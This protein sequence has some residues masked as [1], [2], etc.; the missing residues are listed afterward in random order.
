MHRCPPKIL[1]PLLFSFTIALALTVSRSASAGSAESEKISGQEL[2]SKVDRAELER[3]VRD[4]SGANEIE[5]WGLPFRLSTRYALVQGKEI[6]CQYLVDE[7]RE[8]GYEPQLQLFPLSVQRP[9]LTSLAISSGGD[10]VFLG[11]IDGRVFAATSSDDFENY[12]VQGQLEGEIY[13]LEIDPLAD[14]SGMIWAACGLP[15]GGFGAVFSSNDGGRT[16]EEAFSGTQVS[17][18]RTITISGERGIAAGSSGTVVLAISYLGDFYWSRQDPAIFGYRSILGSASSGERHFWLAGTGGLL[19]ETEDHGVNWISHD[20]TATTLYDIDFYDSNRGV[21]VGVQTAF[22][23]VDGGD[24]WNEAAVDSELRCVLMADSLRVIAGGPYGS[25]WISEDGGATWNEL[26]DA[27]PTEEDAVAVTGCGADRFWIAGG[28]DV[29]MLD[30]GP[31]SSCAVVEMADTVMGM[32]ISFF[33]DGLDSPDERI[34]LSA[35]YDSYSSTEPEVCAPGADDNATGVAA[36]LESARALYGERTGKTVEFILFDGEELGLRG[37]HYF[38]AN[39]DTNVSYGAVV[40]LDMLG[41]D[42]GTDRSLVIAGREDS[43]EDSTLAAMI[44][45]TTDTLGIE[46]YPYFV[47][48]ASLSSDHMSFWSIGG[49]PSILLIEGIKGELTPRYHTCGDVAGFVDYSLHFA[50]TKAALAAVARLSGYV[51]TPERETASLGQNWPNPFSDITR[52]PFYV[53]AATRVRLSVYDVAGREV[54]RLLDDV[55]LEGTHVH[56]WDGRN[57]SGGKLTT[58]VYFLRMKTDFHEAVRKVVIIR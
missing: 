15:G 54:A 56:E 5:V 45:E 33:H 2:I 20:L 50:S 30:I 44:V 43:R 52:I 36:V 46:L 48:G 27:C 58:G 19:Y 53:P 22:Y 16:W 51:P 25:I 7:I 40:N 32:N 49:F 57:E 47:P 13:D 8:I 14:P 1:T 10:S 6:A 39:L 34:V 12:D 41:Y 11:D 24:T 26:V 21:V 4:L 31:P 42:Y 28:S 38:T 17:T 55:R 23:T 18:L 9:A 35:H 3:I 37:S 29:R